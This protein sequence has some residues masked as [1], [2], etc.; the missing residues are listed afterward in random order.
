MIVWSQ[1]QFFGPDSFFCL[2]PSVP[3]VKERDF[4][5]VKVGY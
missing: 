1:I 4:V 3:V 5:V 2:F